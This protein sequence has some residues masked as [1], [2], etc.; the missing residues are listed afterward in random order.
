MYHVKNRKIL[1]L[2]GGNVSKLDDFKHPITKLGLNVQLAS[3]YDLEYK[4]INHN[5]N[6]TL[7]VKGKDLK[8]YDLIYFR[9]VGK[10]FEDASLVINYA[11][12]HGIKIIDKVY[13]TSLFLPSTVA[14]AIEMQRMISKG[15]KIPPTYFGNLDNIHAKAGK[16]LN[17]PYVLKST[18]GKKAREVWIVKTKN[19][20]SKITK[21]LKEN[22]K[23]GKRYFAQKFIL[24]SQ[25]IRTFVIG[26]KVLGA[27]TRPTKWR[28]L[29]IDKVNGKYPEGKKETIYPVGKKYSKI[30][31]EASKSVELD[32]AGVDILE[33]DKSRLLYV[34]EANAA[35]AWRLIK[36]HTEV[37]VEEEILKY[38]Q[39]L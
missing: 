24:A 33:E 32:I 3:F 37:E 38:L 18:S 8:I 2:T 39:K 22:E 4:S 19:E 9:L 31:L 20:S 14:K 12:K 25:R 11:K 17:Y 23:K 27:I 28:T 10:R 6:F 26:D 29:F 13:E 36:M 34:I 7:Q 30:S 5:R 35:P 15:V 21:D 16:L 1:I